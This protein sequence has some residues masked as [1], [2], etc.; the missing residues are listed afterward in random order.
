MTGVRTRPLLRP[1][2]VTT[3]GGQ[4]GGIA[5]RGARRLVQANAVGPAP[6]LTPLPETSAR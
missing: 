6:M 5:E 2:T 4:F 1:T 3:W